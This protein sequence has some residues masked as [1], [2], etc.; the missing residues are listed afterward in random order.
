MQ[1]I[2]HNN[3]AGHG[4]DDEDSDDGGDDEDSDNG[5]DDDEDS[6]DGE[7]EHDEPVEFEEYDRDSVPFEVD[8]SY[9]DGK[10]LYHGTSTI[11]L[12]LPDRSSACWLT[13]LRALLPSLGIAI[14]VPELPT[15]DPPLYYQ[16]FARLYDH[17]GG[18]LYDSAEIPAAIPANRPQNVL[19]DADGDLSTYTVGLRHVSA[20]REFQ[21]RGVMRYSRLEGRYHRGTD[22]GR[23][24]LIL[25]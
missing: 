19:T 9:A 20:V 18:H 3:T 7:G 25:W 13:E 16:D 8:I 6:D 15:L 14:F 22:P 12:D 1:L 11:I 21:Q 17:L 4:G 2:Q 23:I 10:E 5:G 24:L